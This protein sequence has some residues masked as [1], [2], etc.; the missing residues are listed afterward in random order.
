MPRK[1]KNFRGA[2]LY[3]FP[4]HRIV[5]KRSQIYGM[6]PSSYTEVYWALSSLVTDGSLIMTPG[7]DDGK[8]GPFSSS[9]MDDTFRLSPDRQPIASEQAHRRGV[10]QTV[11]LRNHTRR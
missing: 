1:K 5:L 9:E 11:A 3:R 6:F 2:I 7:L 8:S 4:N 10:L